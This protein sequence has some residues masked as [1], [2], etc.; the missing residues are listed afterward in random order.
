MLQ[1]ADAL[2][3]VRSVV[4]GGKI[5]F[6]LWAELREKIFTKRT[7]TL[8]TTFIAMLS[9]KLVRRNYYRNY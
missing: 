6:C 1:L 9:P 8:K 4:S 5:G 2:L 7:K 3:L